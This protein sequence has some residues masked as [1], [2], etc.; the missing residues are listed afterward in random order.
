[1]LQSRLRRTPDMLSPRSKGRS[2]D[3]ES[4]KQK[5]EDFLR[6]AEEREDQHAKQIKE[7]EERLFAQNAEN[8]EYQ[9]LFVKYRKLEDDH[10][11]ACSALKNFMKR[12]SEEKKERET[13]NAVLRSQEEVI[14]ELK[15]QLSRFSSSSSADRVL[16]DDKVSSNES[17][18]LKS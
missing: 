8:V 11:K 10:K 15:T 5:Y 18:T 12:S 7:L 3:D 4:F 14:N 17:S 16:Q 1:M 6:V 9:Q 13:L 2:S